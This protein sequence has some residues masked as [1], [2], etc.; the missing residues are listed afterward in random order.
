MRITR[1]DKILELI[2]RL[3]SETVDWKITDTI[4]K[5]EDL[6]KNQP[7]HFSEKYH[8]DGPFVCIRNYYYT[9]IYIKESDFE[10]FKKIREVYYDKEKLINLTNLFQHYF[11]KQ[12][13]IAQVMNKTVPYTVTIK[14]LRMCSIR[15]IDV[16][17]TRI[18]KL[19]PEDQLFEDLINLQI[20]KDKFH[21]ENKQRGG[22]PNYENS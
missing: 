22:L 13:C 12:E 3:R 9:C 5:A 19:M 15:G 21:L 16:Y 2:E 4:I 6:I 8:F 20:L 18:I 1:V 11:Q 17:I 10:R 14:E 7:L